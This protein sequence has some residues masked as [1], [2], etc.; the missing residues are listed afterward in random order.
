[1]LRMPA[2]Q[3]PVKV[4]VTQRVHAVGRRAEGIVVGAGESARQ[5]GFQ[6]G[7]RSGARTLHA[8]PEHSDSRHAAVAGRGG[9]GGGLGACAP[10][11]S[12]RHPVQQRAIFVQR[13]REEHG[14]DAGAAGARSQRS[15]ADFDRRQ[16]FGGGFRERDAVDEA[17]RSRGSNWSA[18][19]SRR[20]CW[21][22]VREE[23]DSGDRSDRVRTD[24]SAPPV[25]SWTAIAMRWARARWCRR[26]WRAWV[27]ELRTKST[28][29]QQE[30]SVELRTPCTGESGAHGDEAKLVLRNLSERFSTRFHTMD[31]RNVVIIGSGCAGHTAALYRRAPTSNRW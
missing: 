5:A 15:D 1:M 10:R 30:E 2:Q 31:I 21:R 6:Q 29:Q 8:R 20:W 19:E 13:R 18:L 28:G 14:G 16:R 11:I 7:L 26:N 25:R 17:L 22:D 23:K 24:L 3:P 12:R 27:W 4:N 9:L